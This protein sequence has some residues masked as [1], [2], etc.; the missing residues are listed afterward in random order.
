MRSR[1]I[2]VA[3]VRVLLTCIVLTVLVSDVGRG[4]KS[5]ASVARHA[6]AKSG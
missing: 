4:A 5:G 3:I 6:G 2:C 1:N